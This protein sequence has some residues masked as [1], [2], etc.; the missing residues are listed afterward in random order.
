MGA[1]TGATTT[2]SSTLDGTADFG[3]TLGLA[4]G[5]GDVIFN[6]IVGGTTDLGVVN[7]NSARN[8]TANAAFNAQAIN[9]AAGTGTT[10]FASTVN[11]SGASATDGLD[12]NGGTFTF[13]GTV[14]TG[15][16]GAVSVTNSG[17]LAIGSGGDMTLGGAFLQD[18]SG[19]VSTAGDITT[20]A[21]NISFLRAV[22]LTGPVALNS[23]GSNISFGSTVDSDAAGTTRDL[24]L[25][26]GAGS[27]TFTGAV[28][29][30]A[31]LEDLGIVSAGDVTATTIRAE[32]ITQVAGT[33]TTTFNGAVTA[34]PLAPGVAIDL[35]GNA[36][37]INNTVT[38]TG[39]G[40]FEVANSG[41][42]TIAAAGDM[43]L[44]GAFTQ[45]GTGAVSM[46]GDIGTTADN[47]SFAQAGT[48]TQ[49]VN[50]STGG[51]AG[52]I[53]FSSPVDDGVNSY[54]LTLGASSGSI[55]ILNGV[56]VGTVTF[57][58]SDD[59]TLNG[60]ISV[61]NPF[62]TN[63]ITGDIVLAGDTSIT[64]TDDNITLDPTVKMAG[65]SLSLDALDVG[66]AGNITLNG[67][68]SGGSTTGSFAIDGASTVDINNS[69]Q[70]KE[71]TIQ[72]FSTAVDLAGNIGL[73]ANDGSITM[74]SITGVVNLS[75]VDGSSMTI[76][77]ITVMPTT[78]DY[79]VDI[80]DIQAVNDPN[81]TITSDGSAFVDIVYVND[82][83]LYIYVD[84]NDSEEAILFAEAIEAKV[85]KLEGKGIPDYTSAVDKII[86]YSITSSDPIIFGGDVILEGNTS[87][88]TTG[89]QAI[90][91]NGKV[92]TDGTSWTL[93]LNSAGQ[94]LFSGD[95]G[96]E[97]A[98]TELGLLTTDAGGTTVINS[99]A[100]N[101]VSGNP[102]DPLTGVFLNDAV[103]IGSDLT[104]DTSGGAE[105]GDIA[106]GS[107]VNGA[108][109]LTLI[110]GTAD[111]DFMGAVGSVTP[112]TGV[113]VNSADT[114]DFD[115]MVT[116][117]GSG[118][119]IS[120]GVIGIDNRLTTTNGGI[121]NI[122]N[123]GLLT[124][125]A[126]GD[127]VLDGAF[128][129]NGAGAVS[130]AGDITT[131]GDNINFDQS[132]TITGDV[133][134]S[135]GG[136]EAGDITI[137]DDLQGAFDLTLIAGTMDIQQTVTLTGT[138]NLS[139]TANGA[140][141]A[142]GTSA[143]PVDIAVSGGLT[144][145]ATNGAGGIYIN[146][147]TNLDVTTIDSG[148]GNMELN[149]AGRI[150]DTAGNETTTDIRGAGLTIKSATGVGTSASDAL[151]LNVN[152]LTITNSTGD[153]FVTEANGMGLGT[154]NASGHTLNIR[155]ITG[156]LTDNA[157]VLTGDNLILAATA[158]GIGIGGAINT[159]TTG[160][161]G[162]TSGGS[163]NAGD[164]YISENN[165]L[166]TNRITLNTH[167]STQLVSLTSKTG[168]ITIGANIG[169]VMDNL[170]LVAQ[171]GNIL[172]GGG[173]ITA[174]DLI[175]MVESE[176]TTIGQ[177]WDERN[178]DSPTIE[179]R[180]Y[181]DTAVP[182]LIR[183][184][185]DLTADA[186]NGD[187][188]IFIEVPEVKI[189]ASKTNEPDLYAQ[190]YAENSISFASIDG[191]EGGNIGI[192]LAGYLDG[193]VVTTEYDEDTFLP[194]YENS[195]Y[196]A[197]RNGEAEL[198][199]VIS[200]NDMIIT[201]DTMGLTAPPQLDVVNMIIIL[202]GIGK[203]PQVQYAAPNE[204]KA[205]GDYSAVFSVESLEDGG[206]LEV[207]P[208]DPRDAFP[209]RP[210]IVQIGVFQID[211]DA[212]I[213]GLLSS[214]ALVVVSPQQE[215]LEELL[216]SSGGED[217]FLAPP[218]WIDIEM[219]EEE[220][221]EE[222]EEE[223]DEFGDEF[224]LLQSPY[225]FGTPDLMNVRDMP[226]VSFLE[227]RD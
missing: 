139:L 5:A 59:L 149:V 193:S 105:D 113:I 55:S 11:T 172:D 65:H 32:T 60:A 178:I 38:T 6:S 177:E 36:F 168:N 57:T 143:D 184:S 70:A 205:S 133:I 175:L 58:A 191:G 176:N 129:Q 81:L 93:M 75:G 215:A 80:V 180:Y 137:E 10:L 82:G 209:D 7:I 226:S 162:L 92:Y 25:T 39:G 227:T 221:K 183:V 202:S 34:N 30:T 157:S 20:T 108:Q 125:A 97:G 152:N 118:L 77:S 102:F 111:I 88:S 48:L 61:E 144:A 95:I 8:V 109:L 171:S 145:N 91:F 24:T 94:T 196:D 63:T 1:G 114:L 85:K 52:D 15:T 210:G 148:T 214:S 31:S 167:S 73:T 115:N 138:G 54:T 45:N 216:A 120:A 41:L 104:I 160:T 121:V 163:G 23:A 155:A 47:I 131:T 107:T 87:Y 222:T 100:I 185:G 122:T 40:Q 192:T 151:N 186:S 66:P 169:N 68:V 56:S 128:D 86:A 223:F 42:L 26:A 69:I 78:D 123:S 165:A 207:Y 159:D 173:V 99:S 51:G 110:G 190:Q 225:M 174:N 166:N 206:R 3:Q 19:A 35:T 194:V 76:K 213:M 117:G 50:I 126:A 181:L 140:G 147:L 224:T 141:A 44:D 208:P 198:D 74:D 4:A 46:A 136:G 201:A 96:N 28:G 103:T 13:N 203:H 62:N 132:V 64:T 67:L 182:V 218:L 12:L 130:T 71:I 156:N 124:I 217:F 119:D 195:D 219:E 212:N 116:L 18:G 2:F 112:L 154:V 150:R 98:G 90:T 9:Q 211:P 29:T 134:M 84:N 106:F 161:I 37:T 49:N 200:G 197:W 83:Q 101:T 43:T 142:I 21:D 33:G 72:N 199:N 187:G 189:T 135:T 158:G 204:R 27:I 53:T 79:D 153:V 146:D 220:E 17:L 188:G 16:L 22:T 127:M 179:S 164:I 14:D 170:T 89:G